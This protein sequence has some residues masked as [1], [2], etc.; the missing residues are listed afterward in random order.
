MNIRLLIPFSTLVLTSCLLGG[1]S[2]GCSSNNV[3]NVSNSSS[4]SVPV[5]ENILSSSEYCSINPELKPSCQE[6]IPNSS[7]DQISLSNE[8]MN[9]SS[10]LSINECESFT[11]EYNP[12]IQYGVLIDSRDGHQYKTVQIKQQIWMAENLNFVPKNGNVK[13]T[14]N[15]PCN[16]QKYG[17]LYDW[18]TA[19]NFN[20]QAGTQ[21]V[22]PNGW[23]IPTDSEWMKLLDTTFSTNLTALSMKA[24]SSLWGKN[25]GTDIF[26]FA[27][28]PAYEP[29]GSRGSGTA[30]FWTS[31]EVSSSRAWE[32]TMYGNNQW[33][34]HS[35]FGL[36]TAYYSVRC[37]RD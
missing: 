11:I 5:S 35:E 21:G 33:M 1:P 8:G 4:S 22:C 16:C 17:L 30:S 32:W 10:S 12:N 15:D 19:M 29:N 9:S 26:G 2:S 24:K 37:I 31:N 25:D 7:S 28:L 36:K 18:N 6:F 27:I 34:S 13:C 23:H 14:Y 20:S 3:L